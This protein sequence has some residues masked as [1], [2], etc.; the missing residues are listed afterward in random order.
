MST[1]HYLPTILTG[2]KNKMP[3]AFNNCAFHSKLGK[4]N[5]PDLEHTG[6]CEFVVFLMLA[7]KI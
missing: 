7:F 6:R 1:Y 2:K 4:H 5:N 3:G